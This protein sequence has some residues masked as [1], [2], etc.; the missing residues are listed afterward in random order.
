MGYH[1][2]NIGAM[3][4]PADTFCS[5]RRVE[6]CKVRR[7]EVGSESRGDCIWSK[8]L[9]WTSLRVQGPEDTLMSTSSCEEKPADDEG[10]V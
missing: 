7:V 9:N 10:F 5:V 8:P 1:R 2:V 3:M 4:D 6:S